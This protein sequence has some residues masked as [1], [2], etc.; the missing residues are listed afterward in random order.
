MTIPTTVTDADLR[1][2]IAHDFGDWGGGNRLAAALSVSDTTAADLRAGRG[3]LHKA[4]AYYGFVAAGPGVWKRADRR[5][6][7]RFAGK[8]N[9]TP[10]V[11]AMLEYELSHGR[12]TPQIA[13][14]IGITREKLLR[15]MR[16]HGVKKPNHP[17]KFPGVNNV[18]PGIHAAAGAQ[19]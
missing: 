12:T 15:V 4:A 16:L 14:D 17:L 19:S 8:I 9:W 13:A 7:P 5:I 10:D 2:A 18:P 1:A 11:I 6:N 3:D